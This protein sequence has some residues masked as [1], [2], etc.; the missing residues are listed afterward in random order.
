M[1]LPVVCW[2]GDVNWNNVGEGVE[3]SVPNAKHG[4]LNKPTFE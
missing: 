4:R 2:V 3:I 1:G